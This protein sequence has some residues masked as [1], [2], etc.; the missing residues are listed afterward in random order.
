MM[1]ADPITVILA[2]HARHLSLC[3]LLERIADSLPDK[4]DI[5]VCGIV[6]E[7]LTERVDRHHRFEDTI[8]FP[9][10]RRRAPADDRLIGS[11]DRLVQEHHIDEGHAGEVIELLIE[12]RRGALGVS[13]DTAGYMLRGLFEGMRRHIAYENDYI[14]PAARRLLTPADLHE[15]RVALSGVDRINKG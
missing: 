1:E 8:F 15:L 14:L 6:L 12:I 4:V 2:H 9:L 11:L 13:P 3:D 5:A 10:L 7:G